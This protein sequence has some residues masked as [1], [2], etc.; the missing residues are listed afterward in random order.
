M[1]STNHDSLCPFYLRVLE[2]K[3]ELKL[4]PSSSILITGVLL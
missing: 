1:G 2:K 3:V 4:N